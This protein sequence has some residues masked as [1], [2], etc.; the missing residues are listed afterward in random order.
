MNQPC[1]YMHQAITLPHCTNCPSYLTICKPMVGNEG[2]IY[3]ESCDTY[4]C[5]YCTHLTCPLNEVQ[6]QKGTYNYENKCI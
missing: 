3:S 6:T 2:Y 4:Y 1:Y 5:Y